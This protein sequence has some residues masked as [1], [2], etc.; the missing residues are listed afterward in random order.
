MISEVKVRFMS[1]IDREY[2]EIMKDPHSKEE[3]KVIHDINRKVKDL[4]LN[5]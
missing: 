2:T 1:A 3:I 5:L 4:I